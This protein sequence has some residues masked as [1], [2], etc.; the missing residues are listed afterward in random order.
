MLGRDSRFAKIISN[1]NL[2]F[3]GLQK[4]N[5]KIIY[6]PDFNQKPNA[7]KYTYYEN[8]NDTMDREIKEIR[9]EF[10]PEECEQLLFVT[11]FDATIFKL[12]NP[13][14]SQFNQISQSN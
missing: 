2:R 10:E 7:K 5:H 9:M 4:A 3:S 12:I 1:G 8:M 13:M 11:L 6:T 14:N